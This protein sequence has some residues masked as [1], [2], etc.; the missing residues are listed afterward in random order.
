[1]IRNNNYH[2]NNT[3][4]RLCTCMDGLN[5]MV[6]ERTVGVFQL[7]YSRS[8]LSKRWWW[9]MYPKLLLWYVVF[10]ASCIL[11]SSTSISSCT[12]MV[13]RFDVPIRC[14]LER[15]QKYCNFLYRRSSSSNRNF[16]RKAYCRGST[17]TWIG[18]SRYDG[19]AFAQTGVIASKCHGDIVR[20]RR[21]QEP[22]RLK[23]V[24]P[25][26]FL[27]RDRASIAMNTNT[28]TM[29]THKVAMEQ[30]LVQLHSRQDRVNNQDG[31]LLNG[32]S[33]PSRTTLTQYIEEQKATSEVWVTL[34][35]LILSIQMACKIMASNLI[36]RSNFL[37]HNDTMQ[38]LDELCTIVMK[39]ALQY[40][41]KCNVTV[42][43]VE[44]NQSTA[45]RMVAHTVGSTSYVA[46]IHPLDVSGSYSDI[47]TGTGTIF[48]IYRMNHSAI[49]QS[50]EEICMSGYCWYGSSTVLVLSATN[51]V[52]GFTLD[53]HH[54]NEF[55]W[56]HPNVKI[57]SSSSVLSQSPTMMTNT[58]T[59][60]ASMTTHTK[61]ILRTITTY[62]GHYYYPT[63][64]QQPYA[65][66]LRLQNRLVSSF[67][68]NIHR[69]LLYGGILAYPRILANTGDETVVFCT[70]QQQLPTSLLC[71]TGSI[72]FLMKNAGGDSMAVCENKCVYRLLDK[73]QPLNNIDR[74][75]CSCYFGNLND[76]AVLESYFVRTNGTIAS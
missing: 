62:P 22:Q 40:T 50:T 49:D 5:R 35:P 72:A 53:A 23:L 11:Y 32:S 75:S 3:P 4:T 36:H 24:V 28:V 30:H 1:M 67:V 43:N 13:R 38:R 42:D 76:I 25:N 34:E 60:A 57:Q 21:L 17:E 19:L 44:E 18:S 59:T 31:S 9:Y 70:P 14:D 20:K 64:S 10:L 63:P 26:D 41:G 8:R 6:L 68:G 37:D 47:S 12:I 45:Q 48:G 39:N 71:S 16:S 51:H 73:T 33:S 58:T 69:T 15:G 56:T 52:Q 66:E 55:I 27:N 54:G 29:A 46:Y 7:Q 61:K 65:D 74:Q 2:R